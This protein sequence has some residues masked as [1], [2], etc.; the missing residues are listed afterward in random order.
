MSLA[1]QRIF[2]RCGLK[3]IKT[4]ASGGVFTKL[5]TYEFQLPCEVGEDKI[6]FCPK[7]DFAVNFEVLNSEIQNCPKCKEKLKRTNAIELGH[8][9]SLGTKYSQD[10]N[11]FYI[12]KK[13][14]KKLVTMGCYGIGLGRLMGAIV[15]IHHD[16]N[17][18]LWPKEV[19]PFQI[20]L[21]PIEKTK[22]VKKVAEKLYFDLQKRNFEVLYEDRWEK[23][24]GEKFVDCDLIGIPLRLVVSERT[25]AK[26]SLELKKRSEKIGRLIKIRRLY[27]E[28]N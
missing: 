2:R 10:F 15:E 11:L 25:L 27:S 8:I 13:G 22:K 20:H 4:E 7:C 19:A 26:N 24:A 18:I 1:Y 17:G 16:E 28:I 12:T 3:V 14:E 21:I 6:I 9:F 23:T 5:K